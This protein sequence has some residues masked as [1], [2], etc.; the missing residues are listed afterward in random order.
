MNPKLVYQSY[1]EGTTITD[2]DLLEAIEF[3][4]ELSNQLVKC[5]PVF[6]LAFKE[7]NYTYLALEDYARARRILNITPPIKNTPINN[8][9]FTMADVLNYKHLPPIGWDISRF[10]SE[11]IK[12]GYPYFCWSDRIYNATDPFDYTGFIL[13]D[14]IG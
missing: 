3:F 8:P 9:P 2:S 6:K 11:A 10:S 5:G 12:L 13:Q 4:Y 14:L 7:A 1:V